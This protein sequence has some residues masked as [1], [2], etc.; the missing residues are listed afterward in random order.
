MH[1]KLSATAVQILLRSQAYDV[2]HWDS[3]LLEPPLSCDVKSNSSIHI[4]TSPSSCGRDDKAR[5]RPVT[6]VWGNRLSLQQSTSVMKM[7]IKNS[8]HYLLFREAG[9]GQYA[10]VVHPAGTVRADREKLAVRT[11]HR[12]AVHRGKAFAVDVYV[13]H[14]LRHREW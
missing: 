13:M 12:H 2:L 7:V 10:G 1:T 11:R 8:S 14:C 4:I 9:C 5:Q 3:Q 6:G